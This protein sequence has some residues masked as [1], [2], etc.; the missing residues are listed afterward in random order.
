MFLIL[1]NESFLGLIIDYFFTIIQPEQHITNN[2][3]NENKKRNCVFISVIMRSYLRR[4]VLELQICAKYSELFASFSP[5]LSNISLGFLQQMELR[6]ELLPCNRKLWYGIQT[7]FILDQECWDVVKSSGKNKASKW[8]FSLEYFIKVI[9][10][11]DWFKNPHSGYS[12]M[13]CW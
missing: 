6:T 11:I 2:K 4:L 10:K 12:S 7:P 1:F 5:E 3:K 13:N 9:Y 8:T